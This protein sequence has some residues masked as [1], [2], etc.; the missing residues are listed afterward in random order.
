MK[1][2][3][4]APS[5]PRPT[6]SRWSSSKSK[7]TRTACTALAAPRSP[8]ARHSWPRAVDDYLDPLLRGRDPAN[9]E[10]LWHM[11]MVNS[12]WRNGPV[13]NNAISGVDMALWDIK[14]KVAN[15]PVYDLLGGKCREAALVYRHADG[16]EPA[17][18][19]RQRLQLPGGGLTWRS[20][21]RWA[22]TAGAC[23]TSPGATARPSKQAPQATHRMKA[24]DRLDSAFPGAYY[25]PDAYARSIP[26]LFD[27]VRAQYRRRAC[28]CCTTSTSAWRP[29]TPS[30]WPSSSSRT[31]CFS[32]RTRS[33]P[34]R[35]T[36]SAGCASSAPRR[37]P[38]ASCTTTRSSGAR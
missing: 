23:R 19:A 32:W 38:W 34:T 5:S 22:A 31:G 16:R 37:S 13:L 4:S 14:G 26:P 21:A 1:I 36:G 3:K 29:S 20:A 28:S 2:T 33:R 25:D 10:D 12:Y 9:I 18:S 6:A 30:A 17:G 15:M 24:I 7:P 35:S 11:M 8:S 27:H